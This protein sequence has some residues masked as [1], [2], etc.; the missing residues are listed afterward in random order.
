MYVANVS[1][2]CYIIVIRLSMSETGAMIRIALMFTISAS[3]CIPDD[4]VIRIYIAIGGYN[5]YAWG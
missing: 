3:H 4:I 5:L 1:M 2:P